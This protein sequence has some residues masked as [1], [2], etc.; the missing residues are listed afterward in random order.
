MKGTASSSTWLPK[1]KEQARVHFRIRDYSDIITADG[2]VFDESLV[3]MLVLPIRYS[4]LKSADVM[5][6]NILSNV[7][8][9]CILLY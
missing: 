8:F 2:V 4:N 9:F 5:N 1:V 3:L 7:L 6:V